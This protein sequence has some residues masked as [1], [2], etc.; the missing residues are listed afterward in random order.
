MSFNKR[1]IND[2]LTL[3]FKGYT[4]RN[5][6]EVPYRAQSPENSEYFCLYTGILQKLRFRTEPLPVEKNKLLV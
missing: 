5:F 1:H 2:P 4:A 6:M 3:K